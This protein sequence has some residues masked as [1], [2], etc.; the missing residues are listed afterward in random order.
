MPKRCR[1]TCRS[2]ST[3][4]GAE[5]SGV[6]NPVSRPSTV[7]S[8]TSGRRISGQMPPIR[9][10]LEAFRVQTSRDGSDP[11]PG[12][13]AEA[14]RLWAPLLLEGEGGEEGQGQAVRLRLADGEAA[15]SGIV[16]DCPQR[17]R[18][19]VTTLTATL[20]GVGFQH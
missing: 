1:A 14:K 4:G 19:C 16:T 8:L 13:L 12:W 6:S 17:R 11:T 3:R 15:G 5:R 20:Q 7:D 10:L 9:R 2:S 18:D